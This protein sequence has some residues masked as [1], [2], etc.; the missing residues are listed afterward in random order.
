MNRKASFG[1]ANILLGIGAVVIGLGASVLA[2][3][4]PYYFAAQNQLQTVVD[5]A[6]LAGAAKLPEGQQQAQDAAFELASENQ[7][8][9][10]TLG[11]DEFDYSSSGTSFEVSASTRV[12]TIMANLMC[13]MAGKIGGG[14]YNDGQ[15]EGSGWGKGSGVSADT[16]GC[17]YMTVYA[18]AKALPA[19][20]DT[21]LVID[22]SNSMDDLGNNRPMK[23]VKSSA[24]NYINMIANMQSESVDR[25]ALVSFDKTGKIQKTLKSQSE[26][27]GFN[28]LKSK[29]DGLSLYSGVGWNTN[30]EP[31]LK[32]ALDELQANGRQN[33]EKIII[34]LTDG[35]PNL[36]APSN[37]YSYDST[38]PYTKC[39]DIVHSS[40]A[41][42]NL[43]V[44]K[45]GRK[46]CPV[47]P[48][49]Q[50][51]NSMISSS[52]VSCATTYV[53]HMQSVTNAQ[54]DRAKEMGVTIHTISILDNSPETGANGILRRLLK[55]P[56][57]M[58]DQL[59]YMAETTDGQQ[60]ESESYDAAK[61]Q[62]IYEQIAQD[63]HIKLSK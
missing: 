45:N 63:I 15:G 18:H 56:N 38:E 20:R 50:I 37:Y 36:P 30:Y 61:I 23:D 27:P 12:P 32:L 13:S 54:A 41:V 11:A 9:G 31:G 42:K 62:K 52:A 33:A 47:L 21:V 59:E 48:S 24:K 35:M 46:T 8:A 28:S 57:W 16:D 26:D 10:K 29:V 6:A 39:T 19:A 5:A 55:Q 49:S 3:D 22:T 44:T 51:T 25:I 1:G 7:V 60:Y 14:A 34:F 53:N 2:I 40:T 58:P 17:S 43:C 4:L